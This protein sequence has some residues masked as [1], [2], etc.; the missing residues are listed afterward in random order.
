MNALLSPVLDRPALERPTRERPTAAR[1]P[2]RLVPPRV[3]PPSRPVPPPDL[4]AFEPRTL[5]AELEAAD[6]ELRTDSGIGE[7]ARLLCAKLALCVIEILAGA[8]PLDQLGRWV[9]D[10]VFIQL[11][12]RTVIAAR[13]REVTG[14]EARRPRVRVGEPLLNRLGDSV[15][16]AVV[17]IHQP[18]RSRAVA[19]RLERH[20]ARWRATAITVL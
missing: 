8:R 2:L 15:V 6:D 14:D 19:L 4:P 12:R 1:P 3:A 7:D 11:L 16:E 5:D 20:R 10:S 13:S 9:S 18:A 17:M